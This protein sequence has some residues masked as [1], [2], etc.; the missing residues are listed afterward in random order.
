MERELEFNGRDMPA[1]R[2]AKL[3]VL[4]ERLEAT[5]TQTKANT[6]A[7]V[8]L[9]GSPTPTPTPSECIDPGDLNVYFDNGLI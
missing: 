3:N 9:G 7:I 6:A 5:R 4:S 8:Q 2:A 1:H